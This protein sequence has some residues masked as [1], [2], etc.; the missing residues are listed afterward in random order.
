M[1]KVVTN[2]ER[3]DF[4]RI[5]IH[6][7]AILDVK[8]R[9]Y[10]CDLLDISLGGALLH[11]RGSASPAVGDPCMFAVGLDLGI[12]AVR[13]TGVIAHQEEGTVGV[14]CQEM[15]LDS[16]AHLRRMV[17]MNLGDEHLLERELGALVARRPR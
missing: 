7:P 8:G 10:R 14:R 11:L 2:E 4:S 5:A 13:M 12:A 17:E 9:I 16:V 15:D 1:G 6:R 3:R